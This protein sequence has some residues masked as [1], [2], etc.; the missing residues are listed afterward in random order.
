MRKILLALLAIPFVLFLPG[1]WW[2]QTVAV[3]TGEVGRVLSDTLSEDI[4]RAGAFRLPSCPLSSCPRLVRLQMM[5]GTTDVPGEFYIPKS[6]LNLGLT[7]TVVF[8]M[9]SDDESIEKAYDEVKAVKATDE[10]DVWVIPTENLFRK[11]LH[12]KVSPTALAALRNYSIDQIMAN[13]TEVEK[14]VL[15]SVRKEVANTPVEVFSI[16]FTQTA[17]PPAVVKAKS[18]IAEAK[19]WKKA[20]LEKLKAE[21]EVANQEKALKLKQARIDLEVDG[22]IADNMT[23]Q[24]ATYLLLQTLQVAAEKG[25]S[26]TIHPSMFPQGALNLKESKRR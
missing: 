2:G 3:P 21:L 26:F 11:Y 17:W 19:A 8:A 15:Q 13:Q 25:T 9:K 22:I 12:P 6:D 10:T 23:P 16:T 14:F 7:L 20:R 18:E 1:C 4:K 5:T 24:L